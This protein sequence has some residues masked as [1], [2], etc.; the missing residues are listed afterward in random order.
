MLYKIIDNN[1]IRLIRNSIS[2][3]YGNME[4]TIIQNTT[5]PPFTFFHHFRARARIFDFL[6][7]WIFAIVPPGKNAKNVFHEEIRA[8][9][10]DASG[11]RKKE[12]EKSLNPCL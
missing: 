4:N 1:L 2:T 9:K 11:E 5:Y 12:M 3:K 6:K 10:Y 8:E 7:A